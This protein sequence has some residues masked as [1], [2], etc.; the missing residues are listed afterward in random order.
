MDGDKDGNEDKDGDKDKDGKE[1]EDGHED[2]N[3]IPSKDDNNNPVTH[4]ALCGVVDTTSDGDAGTGQ[5]TNPCMEFDKDTRTLIHARTIFY[6]IAGYGIKLFMYN[7]LVQ[8]LHNKTGDGFQLNSLAGVKLHPRASLA[9]H[10]VFAG[11]GYQAATCIQLNR[12]AFKCG[13]CDYP[14]ISGVI[15]A[16]MHYVQAKN[17]NHRI[18]MRCSVLKEHNI[19]YKYGC[20]LEATGTVLLVPIVMSQIWLIT[21][22]CGYDQISYH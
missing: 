18:K 12:L 11:A 4:G 16:A 8:A 3:N 1:N 20:N 10:E 7:G 19:Q 14:Y 21:G 13:C 6:I 17:L 22:M 2:D 9:A 15:Q 5:N